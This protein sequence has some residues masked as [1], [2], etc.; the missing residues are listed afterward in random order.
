MASSVVLPTN[1]SECNPTF[2]TSVCPASAP[3]ALYKSISGLKRCVSPPIMATIS[4]KPNSPARTNDSGVPP[5]PNQ[6]GNFF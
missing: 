1:P 5:T 4:G 6:M 2:K 3:A